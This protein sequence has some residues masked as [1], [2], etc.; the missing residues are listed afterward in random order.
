MPGSACI[1]LVFCWSRGCLQEM[2]TASAHK[3]Q[4]R[5]QMIQVRM[6]ISM[7]ELSDRLEQVAPLLKPCAEHGSRNKLVPEVICHQPCVAQ[8][9]TAGLLQRGC[10]LLL[11]RPIRAVLQR[12][13][14]AGH[15]LHP[16]AACTGAGPPCMVPG[17]QGSSYWCWPVCCCTLGSVWWVGQALHS[18]GLQQRPVHHNTLHTH[19][20]T[21]CTTSR[22]RKNVVG[23]ILLCVCKELYRR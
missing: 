16:V 1:R 21:M 22:G 19:T 15:W 11:L 17:R 20:K 10:C 14:D 12:L 3:Q 8:D 18:V 4:R 23:V 7:L 9:A 6:T 2:V 13:C 5:M